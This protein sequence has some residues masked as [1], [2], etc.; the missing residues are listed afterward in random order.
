MTSY[1]PDKDLLLVSPC[2][3]DLISFAGVTL[4]KRCV[5]YGCVNSAINRIMYRR[6]SRR[7]ARPAKQKKAQH[8]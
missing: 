4:G 3:K 8:N 1:D 2:M 5:L 7:N 6:A